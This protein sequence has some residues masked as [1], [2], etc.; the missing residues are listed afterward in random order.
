M[1]HLPARSSP[2][3][4]TGPGCRISSNC[5]DLISRSISKLCKRSGHGTV[6][7]S[8][9]CRI[10]WFSL[11]ATCGTSWAARTFPIKCRLGCERRKFVDPALSSISSFCCHAR[12]CGCLRQLRWQQSHEHNR[13]HSDNFRD[14]CPTNYSELWPRRQLCERG[15]YECY[16]LHSIKLDLSDD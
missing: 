6:R 10:S 16:S 9:N 8:F 3:R 14:E 7:C 2:S 13:Q 1:F 12:H 15:I 5:W 11:E 4:G